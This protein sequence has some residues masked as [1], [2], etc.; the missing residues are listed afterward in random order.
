MESN[1]FCKNIYLKKYP[2]FI[3]IIFIGLKLQIVVVFDITVTVLLLKHVFKSCPI[4][5]FDVE[6]N[7][8]KV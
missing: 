3:F 5:K 4:K 6:F 8:R 2:F 1:Q 7:F